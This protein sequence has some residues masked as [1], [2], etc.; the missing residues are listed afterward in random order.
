ME[1]I[2]DLYTDYLISSFSQTSATNLSKLTDELISHDQISRFLNAK[3]LSSKDLWQSV[4][5]FVRQHQTEAACLIFDDSIIAKP[6]SDENDLI[7]WHFDHCQNRSVKGINLLTAF[8]HSHQLEQEEALR[9]PVAFELILK[10][11]HFSDLKTKKQKR[12]CPQTKNEM[13][14]NMIKQAI[15]NGL[16]FK[17][18]LADTWFCS[19]DNMR[20]IAKKKKFFIFDLKVNRLVALSEKD[21]NKGHWTRI[22]ELALLD[23]VPTKVWLKDLTLPVLVC[24]Q[25]FKNKDQSVGIRFLISNDFSLSN[26]NFDTLYKKRWSVE[27]YHKSLKQNTAIAKSPKK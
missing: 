24:K 5:P 2:L 11:V 26:D 3:T 27:E 15:S 23:N 25:V 10:T 13:M 21:R 17:Y 18:V 6:H 20:F 8:Y 7:A 1:N 4:K 16:K 19:S 14:R 9:V 22:D 12:K